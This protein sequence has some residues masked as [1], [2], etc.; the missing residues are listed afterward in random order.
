MRI[1][2]LLLPG[3]DIS[4]LASAHTFSWGELARMGK[5]KLDLLLIPLAAMCICGVN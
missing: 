4:Q 2:L 1:S 3:H 5:L